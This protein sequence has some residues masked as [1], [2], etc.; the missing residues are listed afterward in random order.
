MWGLIFPYR[1]DVPLSGEFEAPAKVASAMR[2]GSGH[3]V[4]DLA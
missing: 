1:D 3:F 2:G 4:N